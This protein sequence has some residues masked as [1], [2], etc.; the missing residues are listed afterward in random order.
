[1]MGIAVG[2]SADEPTR[3]LGDALPTLKKMGVDVADVQ[4]RGSFAFI[5]QKSHPS[6]T[7]LRKVVTNEDSH[8]RPAHLRA[9]ITG[10]PIAKTR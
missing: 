2:L 4:Y 5:A 10:R 6:K 8:K 9:V 1:M 7:V 3:R